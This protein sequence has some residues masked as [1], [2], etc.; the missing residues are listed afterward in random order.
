MFH[1]KL[2]TVVDKLYI[3]RL[4]KQSIK[5]NDIEHLMELTSINHIFTFDK[6]MPSASMN[7]PQSYLILY[8]QCH[9]FYGLNLIS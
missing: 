4:Y 3:D 5:E 1:I 2:F 8:V 9:N 7:L 6:I